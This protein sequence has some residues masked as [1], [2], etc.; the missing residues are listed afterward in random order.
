MHKSPLYSR[1]R[2]ATDHGVKKHAQQQS[3]MQ[4]FRHKRARA[5]HAA[6]HYVTRWLRDFFYKQSLVPTDPVFGKDVFPLLKNFEDSWESIHAEV[7]E[8]LKHRDAV[9]LFH[10]V[11]PDQRSISKGNNWRTFILYGFGTRLDRNCAQAPV[12]ASLLDKVPNIQNAWFSILAPG[13]HI[14]R[15]TGVSTGILRTH[16]GLIVPH[17]AEKCRMEVDREICVWRPGEAFVFDDTYEH[18]VWNHT[19]QER[20][21]LI[22]D[23]DRPMRF[24]GRVLNSTFI[25]LIKLTAFYKEPKKRMENYEE[26]FEAAVR[27][28]DETMEDLANLGR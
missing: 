13:Y 15:H 2:Q 4:R 25:R 21:I 17:L 18:E 23:F 5:V 26:R 8:I 19:H 10:E 7:T 28:A 14:P 20:V 24:W 3:K 6:G 16:L 9:P 22:F 12:T 27:A 1:T 11:S